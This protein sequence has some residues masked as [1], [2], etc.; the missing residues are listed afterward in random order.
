[1]V[2]VTQAKKEDEKGQGRQEEQDQFESSISDERLPEFD[3]T[4]TPL[5]GL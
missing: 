3:V 5:N 1:M 4:G 2:S